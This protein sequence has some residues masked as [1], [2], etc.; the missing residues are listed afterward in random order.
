M[1]RS[2]I[3]RT[4]QALERVSFDSALFCRELLQA[5]KFLLP[6]ELEELAIWFVSFTKEK[7]HLQNCKIAM[8][9]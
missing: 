5:I 8:N 4:K 7:P 9:G 2:M 1:P 6:S 3:N